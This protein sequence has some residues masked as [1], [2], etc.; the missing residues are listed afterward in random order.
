MPRITATLLVVAAPLLLSACGTPG[1]PV[2]AQAPAVRPSSALVPGTDRDTPIGTATTPRVGP[3][4]VAA[5]RGR[6]G[7]A[8]DYRSPAEGN[9]D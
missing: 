1:M 9:P 8:V 6:S 3:G 4:P 7:V 2:Q 5:Q